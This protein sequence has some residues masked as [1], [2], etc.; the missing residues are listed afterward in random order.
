MLLLRDLPKYEC[1]QQA[2]ARFSEGDPSAVQ[3]CL[4]LLRV[5]SDVLA[6]LEQCFARAGL[7]Q[8]RFTVLMLL[9]KCD[10]ACE[11][12]TGAGIPG[13]FSPSDLAE[14]ACVTRATMTG[15][16]DGLERDGLIEREPNPQD[17]RMVAVRITERG[18][19][20]LEGMLP[21]YFAL[22]ARLMRGLDETER[23]R[24]MQ[25]LAIV[26]PAAGNDPASE[27]ETEAAA[28]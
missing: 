23:E 16:L 11:A 1:I 9:S 13:D 24:L 28:T 27:P 20:H 8:G 21:E 22:V 14:R 17:R 12:G 5:A 10:G 25:L 7:S 4:L 26:R 6:E 2:A 3:T 19:A 15:L 18:R